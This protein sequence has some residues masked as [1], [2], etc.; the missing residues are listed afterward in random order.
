MPLQDKNILLGKINEIECK[1]DVE[2]LLI[3]NFKQS[4]EL[5]KKLKVFL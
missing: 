1:F 3:Q 4:K 2:F 5:I